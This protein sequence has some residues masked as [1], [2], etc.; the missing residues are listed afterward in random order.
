M[1]EACWNS[2]PALLQK[3]WATMGQPTAWEGLAGVVLFGLVGAVLLAPLLQWAY[4]RRVQRYMGF[5]EV[6]PPPRAWWDRQARQLG[7]P[8]PPADDAPA[9]LAPSMQQR[10]ARIRRATLAAWATLA[11]GGLVVAPLQLDMNPWDPVMLVLFVAALGAQPALVNLRP[12]GSKWWL[13]GSLTVVSALALWMEGDV[14]SDGLLGMVFLLGLPYWVSVHRSLRALAVPLTVLLGGVALGFL[15]ALVAQLPGECLQPDGEFGG[16]DWVLT[17]LVLAGVVA[18]FAIGLWASAR[19]LDGLARLITRGWLSD[20]SVVASSG[21]VLIT[22]F[23]TLAADDPRVTAQAR[24]ALWVVWTL[25]VLGVYAWVLRRQPLPHHGRRL[26]VLR[27][28]S[29]DRRTERLLDALQA[30]WQ[31]A[32][33]VLQIGG[34]DLVK[35]NLDIHEVIAFVNFRLH[36]LFQPAAVPA[37]LLARSLD[38]GLDHEGRFRVNELFCFDTSWK[39]VVEQLLSLADVVLLDLRGFGP[40]RGGT[41]HEVERLA[42]R[43]L[44]PRTV[45]VFDAHTDWPEFQRRVAGRGPAHQALALAVDARDKDALPSITQGLMAAAEGPA[46][47]PASPATVGGLHA[48][49]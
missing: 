10:E 13:L 31:L 3:Q 26:L 42:D 37:E 28:F 11:A 15:L 8:P 22:G 32:G 48:P 34:P 9:P 23:M 5:R 33:P 29:K 19:M 12:D 46:P 14:D 25:A 24:L 35:L 7:R 30:R 16:G 47:L 38:L 36:E 1:I 39:A 27:V 4:V 41:A 18:A 44:L 49:A 40:A 2:L 45:V 43:G 20:L 21:V 17:G 6:Q